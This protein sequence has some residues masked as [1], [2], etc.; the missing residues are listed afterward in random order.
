[1]TVTLW[2]DEEKTD[3]HQEELKTFAQNFHGNSN[4]AVKQAMQYFFADKTHH[5]GGKIPLSQIWEEQNISM[6][7]N[8]DI[9]RGLDHAYA[10]L[11]PLLSEEEKM[12]SERTGEETR[13]V[14][15]V[16]GTL[17]L[18]AQS[19]V[20]QQR[21]GGMLMLYLK[22]VE[23]VDIGPPRLEDLGDRDDWDDD[24]DDET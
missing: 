18:L 1:M 6:V 23:G 15:L 20:A 8:Y 21:A 12:E 22:F 13:D 10:V 16:Y 7:L 2:L 17:K 14:R 4:A 5:L 19:G 24:E 3:E 9:M 11:E